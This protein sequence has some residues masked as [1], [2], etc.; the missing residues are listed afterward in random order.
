MVMEIRYLFPCTI[1]A[2]LVAI[3]ILCNMH[4]DNLLLIEITRI[5]HGL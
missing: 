5:V 3:P 2:L 1:T 4:Y